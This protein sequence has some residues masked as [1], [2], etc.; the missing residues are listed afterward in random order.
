[1]ILSQTCDVYRRSDDGLIRR[2]RM[3]VR[4]SGNAV[5]NLVKKVIL[6]QEVPILKTGEMT[7][8]NVI[9]EYFAIST[10]D[11]AL[12]V[13]L[14]LKSDKGS[15]PLEIRPPLGEL[16]IPLRINETDFDFACK[17]F[18]GVHHKSEATLTMVPISRETLEG[19]PNRILS[20]ANMV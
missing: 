5:N 7:I 16:M 2:I 6:P 14:E 1:M 19:I 4:S 11:G 8:V 10:K 3:N 20:V 15:F 13:K 17:R 9:V 12:S 18:H